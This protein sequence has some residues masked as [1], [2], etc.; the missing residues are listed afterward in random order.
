M[1]TTEITIR[2]A[3]PED[4]ADLIAF[5]KSLEEEQDIDVPLSPGEFA[6]TVDEEKELI[7]KYKG[8]DNSMFFV[9]EKKGEIIG[10]LNCKGGERK[11]FKHAAEM[12]MSV[13][14][15]FRGLGVGQM[16][17]RRAIGWAGKNKCV[18]RLNLNVY[19]R[20]KKAINLYKRFGFVE[21]GSHKCAIYQDGIYLDNLTMA[22]LF[23]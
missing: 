10:M 5:V 14:L 8:S 18:K 20:N 23:N 11:A 9:A 19:A 21:E 16:L 7:L 12:G 15:G 22:L 1:I 3:K 13:K 6:V 17:L 4:A 2:E